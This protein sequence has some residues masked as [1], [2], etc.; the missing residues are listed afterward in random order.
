MTAALDH[1]PAPV[2]DD[3]GLVED[4]PRSI[5]PALPRVDKVFHLSALGIGLSVLAI[6]GAIGV[7]LG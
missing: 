6:M 4:V 3:A 2:V 5:D 7:F 1:D